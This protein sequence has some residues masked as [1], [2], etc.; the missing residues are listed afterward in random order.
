MADVSIIIPAYNEQKRLSRTLIQTIEWTG[1]VSRSWEIIIVD[2]GSTD[3]TLAIAKSF[4]KAER[5]IRALSHRHRG[6]GAAVRAGMLT[7][8]G[9][10]VL[11]MDADGATPM[12]EVPKL[13][14]AL[15]N[16]YDV[17]IGS[18]AS[19]FGDVVVK[20]SLIR[21][22]IG[23]AF[24][25]LVGF[26]AFSGIRD[27]QCGFKMFRREIVKSIFLRQT[28]DGFAF[29]V[30]ILLIANKLGLQVAEVPVNWNAQPGSKVNVLTDSFRMLRDIIRLRWIHRNI[31]PDRQVGLETKETQSRTGF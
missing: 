10:Y 15:D 29:D 21:K 22:G 12:T 16:G 1:W 9:R 5:N 6:K 31:S 20:T 18:R 30:E 23:R 14:G 11:F 24:A 4:E 25:S 26:L 8:Q 17:A 19:K 7:A 27:T 3:E 28:I 2:D 13:I